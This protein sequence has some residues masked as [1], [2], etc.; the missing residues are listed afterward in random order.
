MRGDS[1]P[2][3]HSELPSRPYGR[4]RTKGTQGL[5]TPPSEPAH[6]SSLEFPNVGGGWG[7]SGKRRSNSTVA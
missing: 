5:L 6:I 2:S 7:R 4:P 1:M 3:F